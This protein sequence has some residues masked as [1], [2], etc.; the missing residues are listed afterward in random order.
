M[1]FCISACG[2]MMA[3]TLVF[4]VSA[5]QKVKKGVTQA[6]KLHGGGGKLGQQ[7]VGDF[8]IQHSDELKGAKRVGISVF[9]VAFPDDNTQ[10]A[11]MH[12]NFYGGSVDAKATMKTVLE[13]VD[14][15]T[16]QRIAD[17]A[18]SN[19]VAELKKS[20]Y[21]VVEADELARLAPEYATW[22]PLPN[23]T[24]GRFGTYVAPTGRALYF[25]QGDKSRRDTSGF[26]GE[27]SQ[28]FRVLDRPQAYSRS[29]YVARDANLGIFAVTIVIDYGVYSTTG[30]AVSRKGSS[31]GFEAGVSAQSGTLADTATVIDYWGTKSGGFPAIAALSVPVVS[32][33]KFAE[34]TDGAQVVVKADPVRFE[35]AALDVVNKGAVKLA[36]ALAA[37]S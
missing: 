29:P 16:R 31:V 5:G 7:Q 2:T 13:G 23:F 12:K 10:T 17:A 9:N 27:T 24:K 37:Q 33:E 21:E 8:Q 3:L 1:R 14:P 22:T 35:K 30:R 11:H 15:A 32:E 4:N 25:L 36:Q 6:P 34:V 18:Y 28:T 26:K 20:G 19:F